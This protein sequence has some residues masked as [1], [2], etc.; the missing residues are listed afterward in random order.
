[1]SEPTI[2]VSAFSKEVLSG[3]SIKDVRFFDTTLRDGEQAPGMALG[4]DD[5]LLLAKAIDELGVDSMEIGF[6]ASGDA[7][8]ETLT[9][10]SQL[11]LNAKLYSLARCKESDIDAVAD[12]GLRYI[13]LFIATSDLHLRY[14]L[15]MT[16]E[17]V[18]A[19]IGRSVRY[20]KAK[21]LF[22]QFSCEDA[23]RT[24]IDDLIEAYAAAVDAGADMIDIPD[25]VGIAVPQTISA[26]VKEIGSKIDVP[27]A[28]H[29]HNDLG[30]AVANSM[31][32]LEA[33]AQQVHVCV[34]G[35]GERAGNASLE[36]LAVGLY[37]NYG[38]K[39]TN[40]EKISN[41][42]K[43]VSR[44]MGC[45]IP[46]NKPIVGRNAFAHES[47][48]HVHGVMNNTSTYEGFPPELVGMNRTISLGKHSG[49]HSIRAR[50]DEMHI[51]FP[52]DLMSQLLESVK[53]IAISGKE[54]TD[55]ELAA[56]AENVIWKGKATDHVKLKEFVVVTGKN[57][58][59]TAT[60]TI[61]IEGESKTCADTGNGPVDAAFNAIRKVFEDRF[62]IE[63]FR[64]EAVT[65][66]SDSLC[67]ATIM[68][69]DTKD[70]NKVSVGKSVGLDIVDTAV[71][72]I[73]EAIARDY[74]VKV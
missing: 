60:V 25:T 66:G 71:D 57:V 56:I 67:E 20:A 32:A 11:G 45:T 29:C 50:L 12:C 48:I 40:L 63:D 62:E 16:R 58:T 8:K 54:V 24:E 26:M 39:A 7:E 30:L 43:L 41:V 36:E 1:M 69:R 15:N 6:A 44:Y 72:A 27:I 18:I 10:I 74:T 37:V 23:T 65:G 73:M 64:V 2:T 34:N 51:S 35:I 42:S 19:A 4:Q 28:V 21:G 31:A 59:P 13:H 68:V 53:N 49:E 47:G 70:G 17:Q 46:Y 61:E 5:K 14:K 38:I 3:L 33:G 55:L 9:K 52:E 22:V